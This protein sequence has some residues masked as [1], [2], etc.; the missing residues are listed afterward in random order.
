MFGSIVARHL[1]WQTAGTLRWI[2]LSLPSSKHLIPPSC[3]MRERVTKTG[4]RLLLYEQLLDLPCPHSYV[5]HKA[6]ESVTVLIE[7]TKHPL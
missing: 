5:N 1:F 4:V 6:V 7:T 2:N 3:T